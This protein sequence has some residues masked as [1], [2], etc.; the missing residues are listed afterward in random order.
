MSNNRHNFDHAALRSRIQNYLVN[1]V[2]YYYT[3]ENDFEISL[4]TFEI[5]NIGGG[6]VSINCKTL[7]ML[8]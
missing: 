5:L 1:Q 6:A 2:Q 4:Y 3:I 7:T 8:G